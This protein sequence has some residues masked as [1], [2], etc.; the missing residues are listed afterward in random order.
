MD[1]EL[2]SP[3][4]LNKQGWMNKIADHALS[5]LKASRDPQSDMKWAEDRLEA[6][7]L[8]GW[9]RLERDNPRL[10]TERA[11][12]QNRDL[13]DQSIPH[14]QDRDLHP[15]EAETFEG[16]ILSLIPTEGGL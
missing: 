16:L 4:P 1:S 3:S 9:Q 6:E 13:K 8:L 7:G 2:D 12:A 11:I 5:L 14:L 15:E 10:W